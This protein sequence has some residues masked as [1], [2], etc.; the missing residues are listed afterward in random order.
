MKTVKLFSILAITAL[1]F[2]CGNN[3]NSNTDSCI[4][5]KWVKP[6]DGQDGKF[7]GIELKKDGTAQ[8]INM[9]T[10]QFEKWSKD[11]TTLTLVGKSIGNGKTIDFTENYT[12]AKGDKN[13][14][15]LLKDGA[16]VWSF[17]K[18]ATAGCCGNDCA[19]CKDSCTCSK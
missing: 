4:I 3:S 18:D 17:S 8:S 19:D 6:I 7:E 14:L 1:A 13:S 9:A 2:A 5:G 16:I 15:T 11:S 12:I 10:L